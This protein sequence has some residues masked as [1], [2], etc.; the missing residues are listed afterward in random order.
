MNDVEVAKT[1][2]DYSKRLSAFSVVIAVEHSGIG[3]TLNSMASQL[4]KISE[5]MLAE[6]DVY[7]GFDWIAIRDALSVVRPDLSLQID[8]YLKG[9]VE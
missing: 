4:A 7:H 3:L 9:A 5:Q 8:R 6:D 2:R 1:L